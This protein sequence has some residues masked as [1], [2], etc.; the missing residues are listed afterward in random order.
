MLASVKARERDPSGEA[1][2]VEVRHEAAGGAQ[3]RGLAM[4]G[5]A[6]QQ[7]ELARVDIE[8][9]VIQRGGIHAR[10]AVGDPLE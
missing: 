6:R 9:H 5:E 4:P 10:V 1:S 3:E 8:A 2:A 7:T